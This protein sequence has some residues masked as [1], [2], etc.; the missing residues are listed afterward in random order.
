MSRPRMAANRQLP[1]NL[2]RKTDKRNG[3][4]YYAYRDPR[5]GKD[6][7]LGT[8]IEAACNDAQALNAA[9]YA[10]QRAARLAALAHPT[11]P[12]AVSLNR[13][14]M[15][16]LEL[17][18]KRGLAANTIRTRKSHV[19][20][21]LA[22]LGRDTPIDKIKVTQL[23]EAI[24]AYEADGKDR[25]ALAMRT[26]AVEL[27]KDALAEGWAED[28]LAER[29]RA[30]TVI[31]KR[32]RL[33]LDDFMRIHAAAGA[34]DPWIRRAMELALVTAQRREDLAAAEFRQSGAGAVAWLDGDTLRVIQQKTG[35]RVC[36]PLDIAIAGFK[37]A[38]VVKDC[39]DRIVSRWLIHHQRPRTKSRP[40]DQVWIDTISKG[41]ARA[42]DLAG[43]TGEPGKTPPTFHEIR[44]LAIRLYTAAYGKDF[45]QAIAGHKDAAT[46]EIYRDVRGAEWVMVRVNSAA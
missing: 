29:T 43:I 39:R 7:G 1:D 27:W 4:T 12:A 24:A 26:A 6:H 34:L 37:L 42:R 35:N 31:V 44:S 10:S 8:D 5:T 16:H 33:T 25:T 19:N 36:I 13:L 14:A 20:A 18:E 41:F 17:C 45:A 28:N 3:K 38:D 22:R 23:A 32:S 30:P 46:T 21:W 9:I 15:R 2:R 11:G 40:G